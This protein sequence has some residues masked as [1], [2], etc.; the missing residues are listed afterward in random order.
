MK[1]T[2]IRVL[3]LLGLSALLGTSAVQAQGPTRFVIPFG[4]TVGTQ[5]L[6]AGTY[7]VG[8]VAPQVLQLQDEN[9][10]SN[11]IFHGISREPSK[12]GSGQS[13]LTFRRCGDRYFLS[14]WASPDQSLE[15]RESAAEKK[16]IAKQ[17]AAS[18]PVLIASS[19]K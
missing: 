7:W 10:H 5:S 11:A 1:T 19:M 4:F 12:N 16:M 6:S 15:L 8:A 3:T 17:A 18:A 2:N 9:G 14:R 13:I